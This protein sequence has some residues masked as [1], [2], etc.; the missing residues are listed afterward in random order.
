MFTSSGKTSSGAIPPIWFISPGPEWRR[1][2]FLG[3]PK[4]IRPRVPESLPVGT[5]TSLATGTFATPRT[6]SRSCQNQFDNSWTPVCL[7]AGR[8]RERL[9]VWRQSTGTADDISWP[10]S[11]RLLLPWFSERIQSPCQRTPSILSGC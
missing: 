6:V 10:A 8:R 5:S 11:K 3:I 2:G 1:V 7:L 4:S 9:M